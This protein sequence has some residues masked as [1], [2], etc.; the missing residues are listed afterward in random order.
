MAKPRPTTP[1]RH[2]RQ[3]SEDKLPKVVGKKRPSSIA[4]WYRATTGLPAATLGLLKDMTAK[5]ID[6]AA[7]SMAK[8]IKHTKRYD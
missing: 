7:R 6:H 1:T 4:R 5:P 8:K 2:R 3:H